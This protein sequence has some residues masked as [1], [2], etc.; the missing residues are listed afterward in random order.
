MSEII[1]MISEREMQDEKKG[2][3]WHSGN[4]RLWIQCETGMWHDNNIQSFVSSLITYLSI[5]KQAFLN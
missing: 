4:Y 3:P 2:V 1:K 5:S